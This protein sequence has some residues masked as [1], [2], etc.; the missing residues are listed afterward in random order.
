MNTADLKKTKILKNKPLI[1][2][3]F[4]LRW[5]LKKFDDEVLYD[6]NFKLLVGRFQERIQEDYPIYEP[7]ETSKIPD[8][9]A[10]YLVQHS[11]KQKENDW[12]LIRLGP[13]IITLHESQEYEWDAFKNKIE[14]TIN[15]FFESYPDKN[16]LKL[17]ELSLRYIDALNFDYSQ[18]N[19]LYF[20]K[21]NMKLSAS[22]Q[23]NVFKTTSIE[24]TPINFNFSFTYR[25]EKPKGA[26]YL[27]FYRGGENGD[28]LVWETI[29][30]SMNEDIPENYSEILMWPEEAHALTHDV[31]F[32]I[33][34][35][36]LY[37][38]FE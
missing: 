9:F 22:L 35:G 4:T 31:F 11:F 15:A 17:I 36:E 8:E 19:C 34:E 7:L 30:R 26:L 23:N 37:R 6:P 5:E 1:E 24:E 20:L 28:A 13:G 25:S 38:R 12:P 32:N 3:I 29:I 14:K 21:E 16:N 33:I 18:N 27:Q 2:V 10:T